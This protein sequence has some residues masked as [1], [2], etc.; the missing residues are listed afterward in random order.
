MSVGMDGSTLQPS[1]ISS[2][3]SSAI[4]TSTTLTTAPADKAGEELRLSDL[5]SSD[6][7]NVDTAQANNSQP[8]SSS[9]LH[10]PT[11]T[12][13]NG[14][15]P[16]RDVTVL[17]DNSPLYFADVSQY[18]LRT[19]DMT[20]HSQDKSGPVIGHTFV[21]L[22]R[23]IKCGLGS[24]ETSMTWLEM[25]RNSFFPSK[26]YT[27]DWQGKEYVI[28][29]SGQGG[30]RKSGQYEVLEAETKEVVARHEG[31]FKF[32]STMVRREKRVEFAEGM[33]EE[34]RVLVLMGVCAWREK[35]LR[36]RNA[37]N[38]QPY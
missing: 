9:K 35:S 3:M 15:F 20:W 36:K 33:G 23:S 1:S 11:F 26:S 25:K 28:C 37:A 8:H 17:S 21:H 31:E 6:V 27:F 34:L 12:I 24:Q 32:G 22:G 13:S 29:R 38:R 14:S 7:S 30:S 5:S 19:P 2:N 4:T 10:G 18:T 16:W